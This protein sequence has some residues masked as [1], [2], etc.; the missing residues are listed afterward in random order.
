MPHGL[1]QWSLSSGP[2]FAPRHLCHLQYH[3]DDKDTLLER[4]GARKWKVPC[5]PSGAEPPRTDTSAPCIHPA[6]LTDVC[7]TPIM[8]RRSKHIQL[9]SSP[10][11]FRNAFRHIASQLADGARSESL[12]RWLDQSSELARRCFDSH[13]GRCRKNSHQR[14][15]R[16]TFR[17]DDPLP[18][19]PPDEGNYSGYE[20]SHH[21]VVSCHFT[22]TS[23]EYSRLKTLH[24][25]LASPSSFPCGVLIL[26]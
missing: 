8:P 23:A 7:I 26:G 19:K 3:S 18:P 14:L 6:R 25:V 16:W 21:V 10:G 1:P 13:P 5:M 12:F 17:H 20:R 2:S 22:V 11:A 15:D 24:R 4:H 9:A